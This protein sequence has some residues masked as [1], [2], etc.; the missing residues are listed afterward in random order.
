M[1]VNRSDLGTGLQ[2]LDKILKGV[3]PGDNIVWHT[4]SIGIFKRF[5]GHFYRYGKTRGQKIV[6]FRF[7]SHVP[8]VEDDAAQVYRLDPAE[9]FEKFIN[10]IHEVIERNGRGG[11]YVFD[12]LSDLATDYYSDQMLAN[13]FLLTC[14]FLLDVEAIAYFALLKNRHSALVTT[15]VYDTCQV[16]IDV[17]DHKGKTYI[18]PV[19]VQ[20]RYSSTMHMLHECAEDNFKP[21]T[22]SSLNS[23]ILTDVSFTG[24]TSADRNIDTWVKTVADAEARLGV[25]G[26]GACND[27]E[28]GAILEKLLGMAFTRD[29]KILGLAKKYIRPEDAIRILKR[30]VGSGFIGGKSV[31]MLLARAILSARDEKW[32]DVL[33]VHDSFYIGSDV[34]YTF[35]VRNGCWW[36][37]EQQK[38]IETFLKNAMY[39]RRLILT[40][41]FPEFI[42]CKFAEILDYFGQ[43]PIIVRSSSLLEDN[44]GNSFSGK[45]ESVFCPNQ[46]SRESRLDNFMTAIRT[47]YASALSEKALRY[48]HEFSILDK[49]EQMSLLVQRV[50]GD[51]HG[52]MFY[53]LVAGVAYS[54]NPYV[55]NQNIKPESGVLRLVF[56]LGT[57]AVDSRDDDY[58]RVVALNDP[59]LRP[60]TNPDEVRK[61]S[62]KRADV[63][64]L[65]ANQLVA[66]SVEDVIKNG[67]LH[68]FEYVASFDAGL[69]ARL[70]DSGGNADLAWT[71]TFENL[72]AKTDF[73][74]NMKE[75]LR[76]IQDAYEYP[77]DVE[78]TANL[79][80]EG[81]CKINI[82]QC[83][84]FQGK[85]NYQIGKLENIDPKNIVFRTKGPVIGQSRQIRIDRIVFVHPQ[86]YFEL[87][88]NEKYTIARL[89][90]KI[91]NLEKGRKDSKLLL[92][93]PGR[94]GTS[95]PSLGVPVSFAEIGK[96][97]VLCEIMEMGGGI[98]PDVSL[99]THFFNDI[100][101][102]DILY[103]ALDPRAGDTF[104][105][106]SYFENMETDDSLHVDG[107]DDYKDVIRI[108]DCPC[109][110]GSGGTILHADSL[111]SR[112]ICYNK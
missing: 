22:R 36:I 109:R 64:D 32:E 54:Y 74:P 34:F 103:F 99:G 89:V 78:F 25:T 29:E 14:P 73:I 49:D 97:S 45:Y 28:K 68:S 12:C 80:E 16:F 93:G 65:D 33:E 63:I 2:E 66:A 72:F 10:A 44:F 6:Y 76:T 9:G 57:R 84:P 94:W 107:L 108:A 5:A 15:T 17:Y 20:Q 77:V 23:E 26:S 46:G 4:D 111:G 100:V 112:V 40:G 81:R 18:H 101:D 56:G 35:M 88:V 21:V 31:G 50:S 19:K 102:F 106:R 62:Q 61:Y 38:D 92:M 67:S 39:A 71:V 105:D 75:L 95:T 82:V 96:I 110:G 87:P 79:T 98:I 1:V 83:R 91:I 55:W 47:I 7:S 86:K 41:V 43:S 30:T 90:G 104:L 37:R 53:P 48:R 58:T 27:G 13:F 24:K 52:H 51:L 85:N 60:E 11:Y 69:A 70:R 8:I 59:E 42:K 3:L